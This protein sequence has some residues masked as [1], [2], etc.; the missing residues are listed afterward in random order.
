MGMVDMVGNAC[1]W[2][3]DWYDDKYYANSPRQNPVGPISMANWNPAR[4]HRGGYMGS[5][6]NELR[7]AHRG[8]LIP[9]YSLVS[10]GFRCA[11]DVPK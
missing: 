7:V 6:L 4:V 5:N 10:I 11:M 8:C 2:C 1:E 3:A 9:G